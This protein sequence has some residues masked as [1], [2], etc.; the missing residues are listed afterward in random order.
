MK[1][2][3]VNNIGGHLS[4]SK[5]IDATPGRAREFG[6]KSYQVFYQESDAVEGKTT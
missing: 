1:I 2:T 6:F 3:D 4:T 5:G